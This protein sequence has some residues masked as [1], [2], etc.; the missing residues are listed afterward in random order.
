MKL[1]SG[2]PMVVGGRR[3]VGRHRTGGT[4]PPVVVGLVVA[5]VALVAA[6]STGST[7]SPVSPGS[8][9]PS[10]S[11]SAGA[12]TP[13]PSPTPLTVGLGYI[14]S[15]QFAQF[16][17]AD[18]RG[19]YRD[20]GLQVTFENKIDPDLIRLTG[21]GSVDV[22][23]ADGTSLIPA[24]SQGIP[25]EYIATVYAKFPNIVFAKAS[26]GIRTAADLKGRTIG[27]PGRYGS[28]WVMLQA[29]LGSVGLTV[30]DVTIVEYPDFGQLAG[31]Q[32]GAVDAATGFANNEPVRLQLAGETPVVLHV[33][34]AVALPG[35]GL[36][37]GT[38]TAQEKA[39]AIRAFVAATLHA[40]QDIIDD[41][42]AGLDATFTAVQELASDRTGQEAVLAATIDGWQSAMTDAQGLGAID[43]AGW[44][45][46]I[47]FMK[48]LP[49][50][51]VPNPVTVDQLVS[52]DFLPR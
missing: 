50:D 12:V 16:Y 34:A 22:S 44:Q 28:G 25:V 45:A 8:A 6:C 2:I 18:Q 39:P 1:A 49:G 20:A 42:A 15:V 35:N 10:A 19:Y 37:V 36:I 23:L 32:Q 14:P 43:T 48:T 31:V 17:L 38:T 11:G 4:V 30:D 7:A 40:M 33:D 5:L 13:A 47:D 9:A 3:M 27:T 52:T 24:V 41:P 21:Q 51:L 26:S 46:S 29:L